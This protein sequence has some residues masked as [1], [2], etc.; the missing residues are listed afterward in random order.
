MFI[1]DNISAKFKTCNFTGYISYLIS[2][3]VQGLRNFFLIIFNRLFF[4]INP[5]TLSI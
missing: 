4:K 5:E 3:F 2:S 1:K